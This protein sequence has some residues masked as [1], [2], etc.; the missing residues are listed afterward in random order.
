MSQYNIY[1]AV[2]EEYNFPPVVRQAFASSPEL[3]AV[4]DVGILDKVPD[5]VAAVIAKDASIQQAAATAAKTAVKAEVGDLDLVK[6]SDDRLLKDVAAL[7]YAVPFMD[8]DGV[9][10]GGFYDDGTWN[11][12]APPRIQGVKGMVGRPL[13]APGW[14]YVETDEDGYVSMGI[15]DSGE[16]HIS[17]LSTDTLRLANSMIGY[18]RSDR[19]KVSCIGDSLTIGYFDGSSSGKV[20]DSYPSKLQALVPEGVEV[21]NLGTSGWATDEVAVKIGAIPLPLTS[22]T[23]KIPASGTVTVTTTADLSGLRKIGTNVYFNGSLNGVAGTITRGTSNTSLT[24]QRKT[25]GAEVTLPAGTIFVPEYNGHDSDTTIILLGR[26]DIGLGI[27]G[28]E[29]SI[30]EHIVAGIKRIVDWHSRQ[31]KQVLIL[32][33]TTN[34]G[35]VRGTAGHTTV[36]K[37]GQMLKDLYGPKYL[38]IRSYLVNQ[39]IYDLGITPTAA[40]LEKMN[41][42]TFPP[43]I[44]DPGDGTHW[45]R[46]TAALVAQLVNAY[47]ISREWIN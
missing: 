1:P 17:A 37:A 25:A 21:F 33:P 24:F 8:E 27:S 12:S 22:A 9:V 44:M 3:N 11:T 20:A 2:D 4:V 30:A 10:A 32:S 7:D 43:S 39:A 5:E 29:N 34:T 36:T 38:D 18:S 14:V 23:G 6:S 15:R 41:A 28:N 31:L 19:K 42:D 35:E 46:A 45:S 26:N 13:S 16:V 40:D 47:L